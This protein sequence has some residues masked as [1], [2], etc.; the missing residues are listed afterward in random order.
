MFLGEYSHTIDEK[1]RLTFPA[2]FRA[3]LAEGVV[4][5]RGIDQCLFAFPMSE[6]QKLSQQVSGLPITDP[7]AREFQRLM[8]SGAADATLDKQGRVLIP[9][10]LREYA[11][12]NSDA[13]VAG[14]NTH[15]EIWSPEAWQ[16]ARANFESGALDA[17]HWAKLGI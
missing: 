16:A 2:R 17:E 1:G 10:Y 11:G 8:F 3:E 13:I 6:W 12:L 7:A 15:M 5:T 4:V 9:Q 14:L